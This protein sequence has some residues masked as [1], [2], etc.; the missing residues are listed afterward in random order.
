MVVF[1]SYK[2]VGG[3]GRSHLDW[4]NYERKHGEGD[5][6]APGLEGVEFSGGGE[7]GQRLG[8]R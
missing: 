1:I 4:E 2:G 3:E 5:V 8:L 6:G 7:N